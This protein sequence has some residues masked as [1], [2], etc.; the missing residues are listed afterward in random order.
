MTE[1]SDKQL[2]L[3]AIFGSPI[4]RA[5]AFMELEKRFPGFLEKAEEILK[6]SGGNNDSKD[7]S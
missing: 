6:I 4:G 1:L 3:L 5:L 2:K 7:Y